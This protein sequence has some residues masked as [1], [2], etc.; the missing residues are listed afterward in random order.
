VTSGNSYLVPST[1]G[2]VSWTVSSWSTYASADAGQSF[3]MKIF[4]QVAGMTYQVVGHDGPR[5][6]TPGALNTF[7]ANVLARAGDVL[8][9]NSG[10][11]TSNA[12]NFNVPM[13]TALTRQGN[14]ADGESG[15]FG[16][17][18]PFWRVNV[19]ASLSPSNQFT[20]GSLKRNENRGT[21][22]LAVNVPNPGELT[23][24]G[25]GVKVA[26]AAVISKAVTGPGLVKLTIRA[27]GK[28]KRKLNE[29]GKVKVKPKITYIPT[30]GNAST[31]SLKV[32]LKK[33]S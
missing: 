10:P 4:R 8:G 31:Q 17:T 6:L 25:K 2:I 9:L 13:D 16:T 23:G 32:R 15:D 28:K 24:S 19:T 12:C 1:G 22:T 14:L 18:T 3:T 21:A 20:F 29:T 26:G 11:G 5:D 27:K 30:G 33:K 7:P